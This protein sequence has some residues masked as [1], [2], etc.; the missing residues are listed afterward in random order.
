MDKRTDE[1]LTSLDWNAK[2]AIIQLLTPF[3]M[4]RDCDHDWVDYDSYENEMPK[5][6]R[7]C[8][9]CNLIRSK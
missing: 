7:G 6:S 5:N 1:F 4:Q 3:I 2:N 8:R 9:K